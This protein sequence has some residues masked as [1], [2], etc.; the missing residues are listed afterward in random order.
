MYGTATDVVA[1]R[2]LG[3]RLEAKAFA[4]LGYK[5]SNR[6]VIHV[7]SRD[8]GSKNKTGSTPKHPATWV[9]AS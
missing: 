1:L 4:G 7:D 8:L 2:T 5:K 9:Y 3:Q 6:R